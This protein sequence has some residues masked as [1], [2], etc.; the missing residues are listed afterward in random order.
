VQFSGRRAIG[1]VH[2]ELA[3]L[4]HGAGFVLFIKDGRLDC[5]EGLT[6]DEAWHAGPQL[7]SW[8]YTCHEGTGG[9]LIATSSRDLRCVREELGA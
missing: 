9:A 5:L 1:D 3:G 8:S 7:R 6:Y 4:S 2:A